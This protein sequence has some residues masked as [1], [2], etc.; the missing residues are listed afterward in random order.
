MLRARRPWSTGRARGAATAGSTVRRGALAFGFRVLSL[1]DDER[2]DAGGREHAGGHPKTG[3]RV[4]EL[5]AAV[6]VRDVARSRRRV[7]RRRTRRGRAG[8]RG[9]ERALLGRAGRRRETIARSFDEV[10]S[11]R[12]SQVRCARCRSRPRPRRPHRR[13]GRSRRTWPGGQGAAASAAPRSRAAAA[14]RSRSSAVPH[15]RPAVVPPRARV[16]RSRSR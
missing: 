11:T 15:Q 16:A 3:R 12:G 10:L 4:G 8:R 2:H 14:P 5:V 1:T 9:V 7:G 6:A 13:R